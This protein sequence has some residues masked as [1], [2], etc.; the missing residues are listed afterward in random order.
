MG[1][2]LPCLDLV[3]LPLCHHPGFIVEQITLDTLLFFIMPDSV[4]HITVTIIGTGCVAVYKPGCK[5]A[6][7]QK[8]M[9]INQHYYTLEQR[10]STKKQIAQTLHLFIANLG[11][12]EN[13]KRREGGDRLYTWYKSIQWPTSEH[14]FT[15]QTHYD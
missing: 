11:S 9:M 1:K 8:N 14:L 15:E 5:G 2:A 12:T 7:K 13:M 3:F 10:F 4:M 6:K